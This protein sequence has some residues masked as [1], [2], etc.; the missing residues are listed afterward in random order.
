MTVNVR[1]NNPAGRLQAIFDKIISANVNV[2][3]A[4]NP[5]ATNGEVYK[6]ALTL[7]CTDDSEL[8]VRLAE[9]KRE[10]DSVEAHG[11]E[12]ETA[13]SVWLTHFSSLRAYFSP[14]KLPDKFQPLPAKDA[15]NLVLDYF[16]QQM[17]EEPIDTEARLENLLRNVADLFSTVKD[18]ELQPS[19]KTWVLELLQM[20]QHAI[21]RYFI[22]GAKGLRREF[23]KIAATLQ[24]RYHE[25]EAATPEQAKKLSEVVAEYLNVTTLLNNVF[26]IGEGAS[27]F[28]GLIVGGN[29]A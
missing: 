2:V 4:K 17:P 8:H 7:G 14:D 24:E 1:K 13:G 5:N 12:T 15:I 18:M 21:Q 11:I 29:P 9:I 27:K 20:I 22:S 25:F 28:L 3:R 10:I 23:Y 6:Q 16:A 19:L 26:K